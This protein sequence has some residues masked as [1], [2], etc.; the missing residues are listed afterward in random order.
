MSKR[1]R[2]RT[3]TARQ[4]ALTP[5]LPATP[6]EQARLSAAAKLELAR[7]AHHLKRPLSKIGADMHHTDL[8]AELASYDDGAYIGCDCADISGA[9]AGSLSDV[10]I[11][12]GLPGYLLTRR[13]LSNATVRRRVAEAIDRLTPKMRRRVMARLRQAAMVARISGEVRS[14]YPSIA[15][16]WHGASV[17]VGRCPYANVAGA[18]TP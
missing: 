5:W 17:A 12:A 7:I 16:G 15:G 3:K 18:L 2:L 1:V 10:A 6:A 14:A 4:K 8:P 13:G 11:G 9:V